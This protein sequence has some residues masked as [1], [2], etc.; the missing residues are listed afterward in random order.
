[1][2]APNERAL[3]NKVSNEHAAEGYKG[4]LKSFSHCR[5][6][7]SG[8]CIIRKTFSMSSACEHWNDIESAVLVSFYKRNGFIFSRLSFCL[9]SSSFMLTV[10]ACFKQGRLFL[11]SLF[12]VERH[13][14]FV[15]FPV[16][17]SQ[18]CPFGWTPNIE[19]LL[20]TSNMCWSVESIEWLWFNPHRL[21]S[22]AK[23]IFFLWNCP[24]IFLHQFCRYKYKTTLCNRSTEQADIY[25]LF[26]TIQKQLWQARDEWCTYWFTHCH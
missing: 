24:E 9:R 17:H 22:T 15:L 18:K 1:M 11:V 12:K 23:G 14:A 6:C 13:W 25:M 26:I 8:P 19:S 2:R 4:V 7:I 3:E 16:N 20:D 21:S 5:I 10:K